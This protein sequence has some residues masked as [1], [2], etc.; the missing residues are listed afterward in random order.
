VEIGTG[1]VVDAGTPDR[2]LPAV[3]LGGGLRAVVLV[4]DR[5]QRLC[6]WLPFAR[7]LSRSGLRVVLYDPPATDPGRALRDITTWLRDRG[8][9]DVAYV[10]AGDGAVTVTVTATGVTPRPYTV[11]AISPA[12]AAVRAPSLYAVAA[13]GD[14]TAAATA[15]RLA[16]GNHLRLVPGTAH[17]TTLVAHAG[18]LVTTLT[19]Y[20]TP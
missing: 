15:R 12:A 11:I 7:T 18:P 13:T 9:T 6:A 8:T 1:T 16:T 14:P 5:G 4:N 10:G 3:L 19:T 17:G 2:P 20:L